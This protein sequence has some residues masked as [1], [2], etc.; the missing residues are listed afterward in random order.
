MHPIQAGIFQILIFMMNTLWIYY[1]LF[2]GHKPASLKMDTLFN[3]Q[4]EIEVKLN[5]SSLQ[6]DNT[7]QSLSFIIRKLSQEKSN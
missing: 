5:D 3:Y 4:T 2:F 7:E 1:F 6:Y